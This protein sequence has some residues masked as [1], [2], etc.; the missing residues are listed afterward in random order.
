[1]KALQE[2][3]ER[4]QQA[5]TLDSLLDAIL[6]TLE[7]NLRLPP[8]HAPARVGAARSAGDDRQPRLPRGRR[9]L[10]GRVR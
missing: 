7:K 4:I 9:R 5:P 6:E 3:S 8:F 2:I 10:G 1:M